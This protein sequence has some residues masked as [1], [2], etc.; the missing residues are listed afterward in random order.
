MYFCGAPGWLSWLSVRVLILARVMIPGLWDWALSGTPR[1]VWSLLRILSLPPSLRPCSEPALSLSLS[2]VKILKK[3]I[4]PGYFGSHT[5][6]FRIWMLQLS[7]QFLF[8]LRHY[9]LKFLDV[10]KRDI[11]YKSLSSRVSSSIPTSPAPTFLPTSPMEHHN[12]SYTAWPKETSW[13]DNVCFVLVS[14][15]LF[16]VL[17]VFFPPKKYFMSHQETIIL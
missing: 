17:E 4:S 9:F 7:V 12:R 1:W 11:S 14:A 5:V 10:P 6:L 13:L 2:K 8:I 16:V 15:T 3:C